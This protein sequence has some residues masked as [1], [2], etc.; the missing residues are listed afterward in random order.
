MERRISIPLWTYTKERRQGF[1]Y[2]YGDEAYLAYTGELPLQPCGACVLPRGNWSIRFQSGRPAL[3]LD[4]SEKAK[5]EG[6][7]I[8]SFQFSI[9]VRDQYGDPVMGAVFDLQTVTWGGN[10]QMSLGTVTTGADGMLRF[11]GTLQADGA[12][13]FK[14][15]SAPEG[16]EP[17][18]DKSVVL[19]M[20]LETGAL[21][22]MTS[23]EHPNEVRLSQV[24]NRR[25]SAK[26][27]PAPG[28]QPTSQPRTRATIRR[29]GCG[30]G[31][32]W[33]ASLWPRGPA[34]QEGRQECEGGRLAALQRAGAAGELF[35]QVCAAR[36]LRLRLRR[37]ADA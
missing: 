31:W 2:L 21:S 16:Y 33:P 19:E 10:D 3:R 17:M 37:A 23:A 1:L 13:W 6:I 32:H 11:P 8:N 29:C 24:L 4:G 7:R 36:L 35:R 5:I 14:Q 20:D 15:I 9:P 30:A 26:P 18:P 22:A 34:A 27:T 12:Y 25:L 28:P